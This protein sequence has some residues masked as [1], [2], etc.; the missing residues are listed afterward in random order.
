MVSCSPERWHSRLLRTQALLLVLSLPGC[1]AVLLVGACGRAFWH[2]VR[3]AAATTKG[4]CCAEHPQHA[5][6]PAGP[7]GKHELQDPGW[8]GDCCAQEGRGRMAAR[9]HSCGRHD[10]ECEYGTTHGHAPT[11]WRGHRCAVLWSDL[12][13]RP[14]H[15]PHSAQHTYTSTAS[16]QHRRRG[17]GSSTGRRSPLRRAHHRPPVTA[18]L[19]QPGA[20]TAT[21]PLHAGAIHG[22]GR[23]QVDWIIQRPASPHPSHIVMFSCPKAPSNRPNQPASKRSGTPS[24]WEDR[25][26]RWKKCPKA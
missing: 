4:G 10:C 9:R 3:L 16:S 12:P 17:A 26:P 21:L 13:S 19:H 22:P 5:A 18:G 2:T 6:W 20:K 15:M 7:E 8:Q 23:L 14:G 1:K 11:R 24:L 25:R